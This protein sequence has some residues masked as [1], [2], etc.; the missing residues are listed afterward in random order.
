MH[1]RHNL[2]KQKYSTGITGSYTFQ[3]LVIR[4]YYWGEPIVQY[5]ST[6]LDHNHPALG[7][8]LGPA[9]RSSDSVTQ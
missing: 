2:V 7:V 1:L 4:I 6:T 5:Y 9:G 3:N 8:R